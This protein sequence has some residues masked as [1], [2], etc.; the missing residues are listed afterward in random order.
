MPAL[1]AAAELAER[2]V[3]AQELRH[4]RRQ[5]NGRGR[6][7]RDQARPSPP[8]TAHTSETPPSGLANGLGGAIAGE[9]RQPYLATQGR[10][11]HA[12][13]STKR[14]SWAGDAL[15]DCRMQCYRPSE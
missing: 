7:T 15:D 9:V 12:G 4:H 10:L 1:D 5:E 8:P 3:V 14:K 2:A 6:H 13:V 11:I